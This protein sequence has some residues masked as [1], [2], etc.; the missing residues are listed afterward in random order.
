MMQL[1]SKNPFLLFL[2]DGVGA[3]VSAFMLGIVLVYF[4][5]YIGLSI[6]LLQLLAAIPS[7]FIIY[8]FLNFWR[9]P[10]NW[11]PYLKGIAVANLLYCCLTL[12]I[13]IAYN[14]KMTALGICYFVL[15]III[16]LALVAIEWKVASK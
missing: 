1:L 7:V 16:L 8:S 14:Q 15:E 4:Q 2:V 6:E 3:V 13:L 12:G 11:Q 9:K 5:P 10:K